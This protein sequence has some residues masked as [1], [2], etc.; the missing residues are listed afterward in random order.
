M[1]LSLSQF[2]QSPH[3]A[4]AGVAIVFGLLYLLVMPPFQV[5]DENMHFWRSY[6]VSEG[7]LVP[8]I[9]GRAVGG[10]IP[11][12]LGKVVEIWGYLP[13]KPDVD[14]KW[15]SHQESFSIPLERQVQV[16]AGFPNTAVYSP[17]P[18]VPQA[19][20]IQFG[21]LLNLA[22]IV[23]SYLGRFS[24]MMVAIVL[25][26]LALKIVPFYKWIFFLLSLTPMAISQRSSLSADALTNAIA[27]LLSAI[28]L[29]L[30]FNPEKEKVEFRDAVILGVLSSLLSLCKLSYC[31]LPLICFLIPQRKFEDRK[32][33]WLVCS[34]ICLSSVVFCA[35]WTWTTKDISANFPYPLPTIAPKAQ[36]QYLLSH[37][38]RIPSIAWNQ[39]NRI[40]EYAEQFIG[41][42]GWLDTPIHGSVRLS[43]IWVLL[44]AALISSEPE[45]FMLGGQRLK[46]FLVVAVTV[47]MI[48]AP[49]YFGWTAVGRAKV[50]GLQGRYFI[51][52]SPLFFLL[53]YNH[54]FKLEACRKNIS[55]FIFCYVLFSS[56]NALG[57]LLERY[58][59][60]G[61]S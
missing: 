21:K 20:G 14:L 2:L 60:F 32:S 26:F 24:N 19:I 15:S 37:P 58:Y 42:L 61:I 6:Q 54:K 31:V 12:S 56:T 9:Q 27:F 30:T 17:V 39:F 34:I 50:D 46:I 33:Y 49:L 59:H 7:H 11:L 44:I 29:N 16:F 36:L 10:M 48:H 41:V 40:D 28:V 35:A 52:T 8:E 45:I 22:P 25:T 1:K 47:F 5:P 3:K 55:L 43:Y 23:L 57:T 4:F 38:F 13:F 18:Y 51:P 53:F